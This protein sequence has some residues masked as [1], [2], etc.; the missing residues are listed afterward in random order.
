MIKMKLMMKIWMILATN[1]MTTI[2][3]ENGITTIGMTHMLKCVACEG[4]GK[5]SRGFKCIPC[6]G[7][8]F[9]QQQKEVS[10]MNDLSEV[11]GGAFDSEMVPPGG[12]FPVLPEGDYTVMVERADVTPTKAQDGVYINTGLVVMDGQYKGQY[13][14]DKIHI[15]NKSEKAVA[16]GLRVL[17]SLRKAIGIEKLTDSTQLINNVCVVTLKINKDN[18]NS[19]KEYKPCGGYA[20]LASKPVVKPVTPKPSVAETSAENAAQAATIPPW[21]RK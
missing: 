13:I 9:S 7:S 15:Q 6:S 11:L 1:G 20:Q 16:I 4:T 2:G 8:G 12:D 21:L 3:T 19:V 18:Q 17:D 5:N 14:W 10:S